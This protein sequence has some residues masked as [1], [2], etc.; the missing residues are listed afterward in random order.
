M[1]ILISLLGLTLASPFLPLYWVKPARV[2]KLI[3]AWQI[4]FWGAGMPFSE[5]PLRPSPWAEVVREGASTEVFSFRALRRPAWSTKPSALWS[6]HGDDGVPA[7]QFLAQARKNATYQFFNPRAIRN[8]HVP[9][10]P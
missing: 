10:T 9:W 2:P 3:G 8:T 4:L 7:S 5:S 1:F 6:G